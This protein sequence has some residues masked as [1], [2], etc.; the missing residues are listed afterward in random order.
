MSF[1]FPYRYI[2]L[3]LAI[4]FFTIGLWLSIITL[5]VI[6]GFFTAVGLYDLI[7]TRHSVLRNFPII[8]HMRFLLED[9]RPEIR[10]Y[11]FED[12][13]EE[14]P[15]S[16]E[17]REVVYS[18]AKNQSNI[19]GFGSLVDFNK[20]GAEWFLQSN[21]VKK[22][23]DKDFRIT[24]G[25]ALCSAP[26]S[27]SIFNISAMS[28]G[29]L[30]AHAIEA[31]NKGAKKGGFFH[32][33]GEGSISK[34][35]L[36]GGD[37]VWEI[38]T[39]YF[40]CRDSEGQFDRELFKEKAQL[41]CVKMIEL[42]LSQGAKPGKGG[43]LPA[44]K[45]TNE[46]AQTRGIPVSQ[47]CLSPAGHSAFS[48]PR[49][50]VHFWQELRDLSGGKPVG[51]K[52]CIGQPWE[53]LAIVKAMIEEQNFPDFIVIDGT[54]GGT[55]AAPTEYLNHI[56]MPLLD[57]FLFVHNALNGAGIRDKIKIG[58]SGKIT[59]AFD[60]GK[61][62][63]LG[64]DF[65]NSARGFMFALGC[66]QSRSCHKGDC[67]TGIAT[68]DKLLQGALDI[69]AKSERVYNFHHNTLSGLASI[70]G[71]V[72]AAHPK[73]LTPHHLM[74]RE[75]NGHIQLLSHH[76]YFTD[77][78]A[79]IEQKGRQHYQAMWNA[80]SADSFSLDNLPDLSDSNQ[81]RKVQNQVSIF[82]NSI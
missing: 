79:F 23:T 71:S 68:Q 66:I 29:S 37:L 73:E 26:Y 35:H 7:Q 20:S 13:H 6:A 64:A 61:F 39:G 65:C 67:P 72:G 25:N 22:I 18:R 51:F 50:M 47:D 81:E 15:F 31:L 49:E 82:S 28:F 56:G 5:S 43:V 63:A 2:F 57:G 48:T 3:L 42:K 58:V 17:Q 75:E 19:E 36:Q 8:G 78:N 59:D 77:H 54:E 60:I 1:K 27:A 9:I 10:Q 24:I 74:R 62:L 52:L 33:S 16:R 80:A 44:A 32:D 46:I 40:G 38:G 69:D 45:V 55:G 4:F 70:V 41:A 11:F 14:V 34:Y 21:T 12:N 30:S 76:Y 53:F